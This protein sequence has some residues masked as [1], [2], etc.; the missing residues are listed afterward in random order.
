MVATVQD[1]FGRIELLVNNAGIFD[2]VDHQGTT[3]EQWQRTLDINLTG[4][5][6]ATWAV[7]EAMIEGGY[8][9]IVNVASIAGLRA[10][11]MSI[12]YAVSKA[13]VIAFTKSVSDALAPHG[14]RINAV[15]PGLIET[16]ILSDVA[17]STLQGLIDAT[18]IRRIGRP[19]EIAELVL[20]LLSERSS[21]TTG[22]TFVASGGRV[23][24]P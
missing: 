8:G 21:F 16:E 22:Q 12:A 18:P 4:T 1:Q 14:I 11:P 24:L 20:F 15:A 23:L 2:Y 9:R 5:Y 7:K 10:R 17:P 19:E 6:L 13:G 3:P